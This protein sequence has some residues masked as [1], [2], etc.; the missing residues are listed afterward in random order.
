MSCQW[1]QAP[2]QQ[3][4]DH[5]PS[6]HHHRSHEPGGSARH[7][8]HGQMQH[9]Q[10]I[11][12]LNV[13]GRRFVTTAAT[14]SSVEGSFLWKLVTAQ[15]QSAAAPRAS[16]SGEFF[17]DRNGKV[18]SASVIAGKSS[19]FGLASHG[20]HDHKAKSLCYTVCMQHDVDCARLQ[21]SK[22]QQ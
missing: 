21:Q 3:P 16:L 14:L 19:C 20:W 1:M 9:G 12:T 17:I 18:C 10:K 5:H 2:G 4:L 15:Q 8:P 6:H 22:C 13:G 7:S 11:V